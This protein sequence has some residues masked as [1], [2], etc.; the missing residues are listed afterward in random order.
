MSNNKV[1]FTAVFDHYEYNQNVLKSKVAV[2][3]VRTREGS[4]VREN[5]IFDEEN[6]G[7]IIGHLTLGEYIAFLANVDF[8]NIEFQYPHGQIERAL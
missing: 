8:S 2:R 6:S 7:K 5:Y 3:E 1:L 4:L